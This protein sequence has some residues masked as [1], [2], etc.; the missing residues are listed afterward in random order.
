M[1]PLSDFLSMSLQAIRRVRNACRN[2]TLAH[3]FRCADRFLSR[4]SGSHRLPADW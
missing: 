2:S 1:P 4:W 3:D